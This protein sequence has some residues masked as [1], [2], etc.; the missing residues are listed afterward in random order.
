MSAALA[1]NSGS[2]LF[3]AALNTASGVVLGKTASRHTSAEFVAFLQEVVANVEPGRAIHIIADNLSAHKTKAVEGFLAAHP[4]IQL[5]YTPTYSSWL[6]QVEI[7]FSK[8]Q[9]D[10]ITRGIFTS[11][12]DL[13]G[14]I[15]RDIRAHNK[16]AKPFKW[17]YRN[18]NRR[19][20]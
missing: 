12:A 11:K 15:A 1:S 16:N 13:A 6:N 8:I 17:T 3:Y 20:R 9:R 2:S 4:N 10:L 14:K 18:T 19:F 7:W 5:H